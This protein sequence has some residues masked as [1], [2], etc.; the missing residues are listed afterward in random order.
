MGPRAAPARLDVRDELVPL[1]GTRSN[2]LPIPSFGSRSFRAKCYNQVDFVEPFQIQVNSLNSSTHR[3]ASQSATAG[4]AEPD[5]ITHTPSAALATCPSVAGNADSF[6]RRP[7]DGHGHA[8]GGP[9]VCGMVRPARWS[10][11]CRAEVTLRPRRRKCLTR[12]SAAWRNDCPLLD[13]EYRWPRVCGCHPAGRPVGVL[14][15]E[16]IAGQLWAVPMGFLGLPP[17][18]SNVLPLG[19]DRRPGDR[20][21]PPLTAPRHT[22][23]RRP[24]GVR[25]R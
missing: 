10:R 11:R 21:R 15:A 23:D 13:S 8:A 25:L 22:P 16:K 18:R 20:P 9:R 14:W 4:S 7:P 1:F 3:P 17:A 12:S 2:A 19:R 5:V 24:H 6:A